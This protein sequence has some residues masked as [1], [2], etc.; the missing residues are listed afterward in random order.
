[1][2]I[3]N[4]L[5][6][7][8]FGA[9]DEPV[10]HVPMRAQPELEKTQFSTAVDNELKFSDDER[11]SA[12]Q[13]AETALQAFHES[14]NTANLSRNRETREHR[15]KLAREKLI[16][17]KELTNKFPFLHLKNMQAVEA[18]IIAVEA[19]TLGLPGSEIP[20]PG[21]KNVSDVVQSECLEQ[22]VNITIGK[23]AK[24]TAGY[25]ETLASNVLIDSSPTQDFWSKQ[26]GDVTS[27]FAQALRNGLAAGETNQQ[28]IRRVVGTKNV[29]GI[30][31]ISREDA[32]ALVQ[33]SVATVA[34]A[35]RLATY[36]KN[37]DII[38]GVEFLATLDSHTC[39]SCAVRDMEWWD[40]DGNPMDGNTLPFVAPPAHVNC[41]CVLLAKLKPMSEIS[42]GAL[43]D[44]PKNGGRASTDGPVPATTTFSD[45]FKNRTPEQQNEQFGKGKAA[46]FRAGKIRLR[47]MVDGSGLPL[48]LAQLKAKYK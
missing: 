45:W 4:S 3:L 44:I 46:M 9:R 42:H 14:L 15:L 43:P 39:I 38:K 18:R 6:Q 2:S 36:R 11:A 37:A 28:I 7:L 8:I 20:D 12:Q 48:T 25:L 35:S 1:M 16:E 26:D 19:E 47:D 23:G 5:K 29:P 22:V 32:A 27:R 21:I 41:R 17:L 30:M 33:T 34:N 13:R 10:A 31:K 24:P 40:L